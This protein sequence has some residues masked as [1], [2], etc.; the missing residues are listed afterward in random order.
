MRLPVDV[1]IW[2][3]YWRSA[4]EELLEGN[5]EEDG[6]DD[7]QLREE[8]DLLPSFMMIMK[9]RGIPANGRLRGL[10]S[11]L[12][13]SSPLAL[14]EEASLYTPSSCAYGLL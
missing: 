1:A 6:D 13:S 2:N 12:P 7:R 11:L 5:N 10:L 14:I 8:E 9:W 4:Q 3:V